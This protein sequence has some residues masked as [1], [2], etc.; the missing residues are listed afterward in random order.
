M[1]NVY[2]VFRFD[3]PFELIDKLLKFSNIAFCLLLSN[4]LSC[5]LG[6]ALRHGDVRLKMTK[7]IKPKLWGILT[8]LI[9]I[10]ANAISGSGL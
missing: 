4:H 5:F 3:L 1:K 10:K 7:L 6:M 9:L 8:W 2:R